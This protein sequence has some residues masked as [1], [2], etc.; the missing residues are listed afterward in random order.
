[1]TLWQWCRNE[2]LGDTQAYR[3][4]Q[5]L[6]RLTSRTTMLGYKSRSARL[7]AEL[8]PLVLLSHLHQYKLILLS[9]SRLLVST[10][11]PCSI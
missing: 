7:T 4:V 1:M 11:F 8:N 9:N 3:Q 10:R 6:Q 2:A 5:E